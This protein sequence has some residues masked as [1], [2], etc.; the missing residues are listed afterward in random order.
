MNITD[1]EKL[2]SLFRDH[3]E[4]LGTNRT[5]MAA[6]QS[7]INAVKLLRCKREYLM[8]QYAELIETIKSTEPRIVPLIH[9]VE[10]FEKEIRSYADGSCDEIRD[11]TIRILQQKMELYESMTEEVIQVGRQYVQDN[12][13][14][15]THSAST[16]VKR[17]LIEAEKELNRKFSVIILKQDFL[18]TKQMIAWLTEAGI[19]HIIVPE[20]SLSLQLEKATKL[21]IGAVSVTHDKQAV[22]VVGSANVVS[23]CHFN[24]IPVYLFVKSLKFSHQ[25]CTRQH[26]YL[27]V[28]DMAQD[29]CVYPLTTHSHDLI[30]L[31]L[32]D[33]LITENGEIGIGSL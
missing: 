11:Q 30:D 9:L 2:Y 14:V 7:F 4:A 28:V 1:R 15:I 5:T 27:K 18:K 10:Q 20:Y 8:V 22:A 26:I 16:V 13:V 24:H 6:L 23:F 21:F 17:I 32:V 12:D 29:G 33:H 19:D 31:K 3:G 25:P